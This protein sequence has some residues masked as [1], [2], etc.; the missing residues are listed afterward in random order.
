MIKLEVSK[1]NQFETISTFRAFAYLTAL[2]DYGF[3]DETAKAVANFNYLEH[4]IDIEG[5]NGFQ[6]LYL[7]CDYWS[8]LPKDS[9]K[10]KLFIDDKIKDY[11]KE[12]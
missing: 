3:D 11:I 6:L 12:I 4:Y 5:V 7:V 1:D 2:V 9:D 8:D 10:L